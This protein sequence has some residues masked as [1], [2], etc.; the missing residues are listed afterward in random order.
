MTTDPFG[1]RNT[2]TIMKR[3]GGGGI[4]GKE[5]EWVGQ[6]ELE[7]KRGEREKVEVYYYDQNTSTQNVKFISSSVLF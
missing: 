4:K 5:K 3:R 1:V 6:K 7:R 2:L